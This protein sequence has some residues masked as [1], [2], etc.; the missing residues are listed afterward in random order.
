MKF[1]SCLFWS[2]KKSKLC[3][4]L[5][6][7]GLISCAQLVNP[8]NNKFKLI[9]L[10][11][12]KFIVHEEGHSAFPSALKLNNGDIVVVFRVGINHVDSS[13]KIMLVRYKYDSMKFT[14]KE[15]QKVID[16]ELDDRDPSIMQLSSGSLLINFFSGEPSPEFSY[17]HRRISVIMSHDNGRTWNKRIDLNTK[18]FDIWFGTSD[19]VIE[20]PNKNLIMPV[21]GHLNGDK[22]ISSHIF[23]SKDGGRNWHYDTMIALDTSQQIGFDE[24][25]LVL[26]K[27]ELI[28]ALRTDQDSINGRGF[29]YQSN[30]EDMGKT[31]SSPKKLNIWGY[32]T[33][34]LLFNS[35]ILFMTYGYR[36]FPFGVRYRISGNY[37]KSWEECWEGILEAES[38][39]RDC[40]YPSTIEL[41]DKSLLTTY[42]LTQK[43]K[44]YIRAIHYRLY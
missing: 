6:I 35:N 22:R 33:H 37:G 18:M 12:K 9:P 34:L 44:T 40:G 29:I 13:G 16:T 21:W 36:Q 19:A 43:G 26:I 14:I 10:V 27:G 23:S 32:P 24:P 42:Y 4:I 25:S 39:T 28:A 11:L 17:H 8:K 15:V 30:S 2:R 38:E 7:I 3:S 20:L 1:Y 31:W 5:M 41:D